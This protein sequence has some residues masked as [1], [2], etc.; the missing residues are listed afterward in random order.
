MNSSSLLSFYMGSK[1]LVGQ[2]ALENI[3][4]E[5]NQYDCKRPLCLFSYENSLSAAP[6]R[7]A[8]R[9]TPLVIPFLGIMEKKENI[10]DKEIL[11]IFQENHCDSLI[12]MGDF[13]LLNEVKKFRYSEEISNQKRK[14]PLFVLV[15]PSY[16]QRHHIDEIQQENT[17]TR[18]PKLAPDALFIDSRL[19]LKSPRKKDWQWTA[20][21]ALS[22]CCQVLSQSPLHPATKALALS[23]LPLLRQLLKESSL[24]KKLI[25]ACQAFVLGKIALSNLPHLPNSITP[26]DVNSEKDFFLHHQREFL[27]NLHQMN[28]SQKRAHQAL[29]LLEPSLLKKNKD[30]ESWKELVQQI[31]SQLLQKKKMTLGKKNLSIPPYFE[32]ISPVH[33]L[34]GENALETIGEQLLLKGASRPMILSSRTVEKNGLIKL[35]QNHFPQKVS[36]G[37]LDTDIPADS[38]IETV[39]RLAKLYTEQQCDSLVAIGGGSVIDTAKGVNIAVSLP[40]QDFDITPYAGAGMVKQPLKPLLVAPTTSGS[41]SEATIVAVIANHQLS[42]KLLFTSPFLLPHVAICDPRLTYSLPA[43]LTAQT[44]MDALTHACEAFFCLAHNPISDTLALE[45]IKKISEYLAIAVATPED[46]KARL[47]MSVASTLAGVAF[48]NSMVGMAHTLGHAVGAITQIPH[49]TCMSILLPYALA[50]NTSK[51]PHRIGFLLNPLKGEKITSETPE[52]QRPQAVVNA[53]NALNQKLNRL[54]QGKHYLCFQEVQDRDGKNLCQWEQLSKI[55]L[56]SQGDGS[57][58]YNPQE[59]SYKDALMVLEAAYKGEA[60]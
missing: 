39:K 18:D 34:A 54:T 4:Y 21:A 24:K 27:Q 58:F 29:H 43:H 12:V 37:A 40:C 20:A 9:S 17:V 32:F 45:A 14:I 8:L 6:L 10:S 60:L 52:K 57:I 5:L 11:K 56:K 30:V 53:I 38:D 47:E 42:Q 50:Y 2:N 48:S 28:F 22:M 59:L 33:L 13:N 7:R 19:L 31:S 3:Y 25:L 49:G 35:I 41:G 46:C 1:I 23:I 26:Q 16:D 15:S 36:L 55:A 44:G 51:E